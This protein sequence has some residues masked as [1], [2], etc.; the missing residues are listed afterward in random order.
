MNKLLTVSFLLMVFCVGTVLAQEQNCL[1]LKKLIDTTYNFKPSKLTEDQKNDKSEKMDTVWEKV[2]ANP[3]ELIPCLRK[4]IN[5]RTSDGF[6]RFDASNLLIQLDESAESKKI[7]IESYAAVDLDDVN[8]PYWMPYIAA[9]GYEGFDTSA[10]GEN[11]LKHPNP[12]YY[13]PQHG[14]LSVNK[15]I[16]AFII[17]GSMDESIATPALVKIA[18][19]EKPPAREIA[20]RILLQQATPESF[21][22]LKK[23][24]QKNLSE[25][26]RQKINILLTKPKLLT[27]REGEP[28][29]T[30]QKYLDVFQQFV[31][32]KPQ[33]FF[34]LATEDPNSDRDAVA[35]MKPEDIPLIR[36]VRRAYVMSASPHSVEWYKAFTEILMALVWKPELIESKKL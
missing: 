28:K 10:A 24:N 25:N 2:K 26:T 22:A 34:R 20:V 18:S 4:E 17:Y 30:R 36:K 1:E 27:P 32:G 6:F 11:W 9:L 35:V 29:V 31:D 16:G 33:A 21:Q 7:L 12:Q 8:L 15:E 13:L 5:S 19:Q 14:P 23:L 3:K